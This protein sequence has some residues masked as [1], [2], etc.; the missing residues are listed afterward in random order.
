[1]ISM[2]ISSHSWIVSKV[3]KGKT[4]GYDTLTAVRMR[5]MLA[6]WDEAQVDWSSFILSRLME[7]KSKAKLTPDGTFVH[8]PAYGTLLSYLIE[9]LGVKE[10]GEPIKILPA[11]KMGRI[12]FAEVQR[13][14]KEKRAAKGAS[15]T[16]PVPAK[17]KKT[18]PKKSSKAKAGQETSRL[19]LRDSEEEISAEAPGPAEEETGEQISAEA[20]GPAETREQK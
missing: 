13:K 16:V 4:G 14:V 19:Q 10:L 8:K 5:I 20:Q 1:M 6:I 3:I 12:N 2:K 9:K 18:A 11:K 17:P 15:S 7:E